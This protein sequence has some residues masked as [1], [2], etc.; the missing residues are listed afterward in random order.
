MQ[1]ENSVIMKVNTMKTTSKRTF[2]AVCAAI[3]ASTLFAFQGEDWTGGGNDTLYSNSENW[4]GGREAGS[5]A[6]IR[7]DGQAG[8]TVTFDAAY[9]NANYIW[10]GQVSSGSAY[11]ASI[12]GDSW[13]VNP[14]VWEA[15]DPAFGQTATN[16]SEFL[17]ADANEQNGALRIKSGTYQVSGGVKV[18]N[19]KGWLSVEGGSI[20]TDGSLVLADVDDANAWMSI[21][22]ATVSIGDWV[23]IGRSGAGRSAVCLVE[24][25]GR[26]IHP[27]T[28]NN[29]TLFVIGNL[30]GDDSRNELVVNEGG[31][32]ET[33]TDARIGESGSGA[34]TI[35]G[36][37]VRVATANGGARYIYMN[38]SKT[39]YETSLNLNGGVLE[40][41]RIETGSYNDKTGEDKG[42]ATV[43]FNGGMIRAIGNDTLFY[44]DENLTVTVGE[45]GGTIDTAGNTSTI[46]REISGEGTLTLEGRGTVAFS[47]NPTCPIKAAD[48]TH[49]TFASSETALPSLELA[50]GTVES[51]EAF[52]SVVI[53][54]GV[55]AYNSLPACAAEAYNVSG[56]EIVVSAESSLVAL[57]T[58]VTV[59]AGTV[60][61]DVAAIEGFAAGDAITLS[62]VAL[63]EGA[64]V[65]L[66]RVNG[67]MRSTSEVKGDGTI[68]VTLVDSSL[69]WNGTQTEWT[70]QG[71]WTGSDSG[72]TLTFEDGD[73]VVFGGS[74]MTPDVV[75]TNIVNITGVVSPSSIVANPESANAYRLTGGRIETAS[76]VQQGGNTGSLVLANESVV[77]SGGVSLNWGEIAL[78]GTS[79]KAAWMNVAAG[80]EWASQTVR[81]VADSTLD[82]DPVGEG[83]AKLSIEKGATLDLAKGQV[84][85][86][87]VTGSGTL[88]P[89]G[90]WLTVN[91]LN[92][93]ASFSGTHRL[94]TGTTLYVESPDNNNVHY[95]M[96]PNAKT[97]MAG[98][99]IGRFAVKDGTN[100]EWFGGELEFEEGTSSVLFNNTSRANWNRGCRLHLTSS[101]TGRGEG[102]LHASG[103]D[104]SWHTTFEGDNTMFEGTMNLNGYYIDFTSENAASSN[105][106]WNLASA[107]TFG[108]N[109]PS[110]T[111]LAF[112]ALNLGSDAGVIHVLNEGSVVEVGNKGDS[113]ING[114][115]IGN[116]FILTKVGA[117]TTLS[118]NNSATNAKVVVKDGAIRGTGTVK[119]IEFKDGSSVDFGELTD[120][121]VVYEG[122]KSLTAP[123]WTKRPSV[124][125]ENS[126]GGKWVVGYKTETVTENEGEEN[127][128]TYTVYTLTATY[129]NG[130]FVVRIR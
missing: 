29:G 100:N 42:A 63:G 95:M 27:D 49:V 60:V 74:L 81:V 94:E 96:G 97:V 129:T 112:G 64:R 109:H 78:D 62:G 33:H 59:A 37:R 80:N 14:L 9:T 19:G 120:R 48:S 86:I 44:D 13:S 39:G 114:R 6:A 50:G 61:V 73:A 107:D 79:L 103:H 22:N 24:N 54:D 108:F 124:V 117:D 7:F 40:V 25:G 46:A 93:F 56:G 110:G 84:I 111:T 90:G 71:A 77:V 83:Y 99:V 4:D 51:S 35:N 45:K 76:I 3:T 53:S 52:A 11:V 15:L 38:S 89:T 130:G 65:A 41:G 10:L 72:N 28:N 36:G 75:T 98:G 85:A 26:L 82:V 47:A 12:Q 113:T 32:V 17:V 18:G 34:M 68:V 70:A 106:V 57:P 92:R 115:V 31:Y 128:T 5:T 2:T 123:V 23:C 126:S 88:R 30:P 16:N 118:I 55:Y 101:I 102:T 69:V 127:E 87:N 121:T 104:P 125:Q 21:S 43:A 20:S 119:S 122:L 8:K 116:P 105:S 66:R 91:N 1:E 67:N 58:N